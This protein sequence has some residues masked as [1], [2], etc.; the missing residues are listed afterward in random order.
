MPPCLRASDLLPP[1][2]VSAVA[3]IDPSLRWMHDFVDPFTPGTATTEQTTAIIRAALG[4]G[5]P[6]AAACMVPPLVSAQP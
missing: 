1:A 2:E 3:E 4:V 6:D 5:A